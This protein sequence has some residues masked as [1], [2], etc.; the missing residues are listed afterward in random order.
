MKILQI[1][2]DFE[3]GVGRHVLDLCEGLRRRG[4]EIHVVTSPV[5]ASTWNTARGLALTASQAFCVPI[6]RPVSPRAD[7][8]AHRAIA[9]YIREHGPFDLV[10]GHS[11]KGGALARLTSGAPRIH[12]P[13]AFITTDPDLSRGKRAVYEFMERVLA[14]RTEGLIALSTEE[15]REG[16]RLGIPQANIFVVHNGIAPQKLMDRAAA[17][18]ELGIPADA[19]VPIFVGRFS[20]QKAPERFADLIADLVPDVP[21]IHALMIG[22][23]PHKDAVIAQARGLGISGKICFFE[24]QEAPRYM[25]AADILVMPSRY[26]GFPYV[27]LEAL[28]AR[29]PIVC[30]EFGGA[31]DVVDG[32]SNGCVVAQG[33]RQELAGAV[34]DILLDGEKRSRMAA[35]AVARLPLFDLDAMVDNVVEVYRRVLARSQLTA[36]AG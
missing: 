25:S 10:H 31:H 4:H 8:A 26:E 13:H 20:H 18:T 33:R 30:Y 1:A 7:F 32:N 9:G 17:R 6:A 34:R 11:S 2:R 3:T 22:D 5:E 21:Q 27:M 23:G 16:L 35:A 15:Q 19:L 12:T 28:A 24:S 14:G 36:R 29:L